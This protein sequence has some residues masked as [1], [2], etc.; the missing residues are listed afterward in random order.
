MD[1]YIFTA[2]II[3]FGLLILFLSKSHKRKEKDNYNSYGDSSGSSFM[4]DDFYGSSSSSDAGGGD[5]GGGD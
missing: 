4:T 2:M 3:V 1:I 5:G